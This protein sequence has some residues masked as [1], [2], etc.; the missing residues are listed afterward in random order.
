MIGCNATCA[1]LSHSALT[2]TNYRTVV[3]FSTDSTSNGHFPL[4]SSRNPLHGHNR[5][6]YPDSPLCVWHA[7]LPITLCSLTWLAFQGNEARFLERRWFYSEQTR[8][9]WLDCA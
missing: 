5:F 3:A 8:S 2:H 1:E 9:S 7:H 6:V 4:A